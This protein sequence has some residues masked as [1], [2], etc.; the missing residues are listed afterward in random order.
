MGKRIKTQAGDVM[1]GALREIRRILRTGGCLLAR[2]SSV[3]DTAY[4]A[5]GGR[6]IEPRFY[7]HGSYATP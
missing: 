4:G 1:C 3:N 2:V 5:G 6:E 7:N